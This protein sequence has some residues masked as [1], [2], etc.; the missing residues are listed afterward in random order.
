MTEG[1]S[2]QQ[3]FGVTYVVEKVL[4]G[5]YETI[6]ILYRTIRNL[7]AFYVNTRLF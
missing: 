4:L 5:I 2:N 6:L 7:L 1:I 3:Q